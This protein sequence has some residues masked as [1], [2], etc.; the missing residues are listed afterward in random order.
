MSANIFE[1][2][3][4]RYAPPAW[5]F[6]EE[7][8]N[9]TGYRK[10]AIRTA[11]AIAMSLYPSRGLHLHGFEVKVSRA[12][13]KK[14]L[15]DPGKAE[16]I[17]QH[18]HFWW[19]VIADPKIVQNGELPATWGLLVRHGEKLKCEKEPMFNKDAKAPDHALLA[20]ILRKVAT[21]ATE[22]VLLDRARAEGEEKGYRDGVA[23]AESFSAEGRAQ[24]NYDELYQRVQDFTKASGINLN[25]GGAERLK[26][27]GPIIHMLVEDYS[28]PL[29]GVRNIARIAKE[30]L[31]QV[32]ELEKAAAEI[33]PKA[34]AETAA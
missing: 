8:R 1:L 3:R 7:V 18:C 24:K 25:F 23:R 16:E 20:A 12:D 32:G 17:A 27:L 13:W 5:A 10:G 22:Q 33:I 19:L 29:N 11:D 31:K 34:D 4:A 9:Q 15:D 2:L 21:T 26:K 28:S 14:E 6:L 30:V